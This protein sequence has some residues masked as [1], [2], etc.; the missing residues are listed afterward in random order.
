MITHNPEQRIE[1][2]LARHGIA[3]PG[4]GAR[5]GAGWL[6]LVERLIVDLIALGWDKRCDQIKEKFGTL[7]FYIGNGSEQIR[8]RI[9]EAE[10]ESGSTC[11]QCGSPG[12]R[13]IELS[14]Y[15]ATRCERHL[16]PAAP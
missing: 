14:T 12:R 3:L 16:L 6:Q 11:N 8:E 7:R 1:A 5:C 10:K 9:R 13:C 2:I 4:C 15:V